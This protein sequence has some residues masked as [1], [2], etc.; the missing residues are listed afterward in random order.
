[1]EE[2]I[3]LLFELAEKKYGANNWKAQEM[4]VDYIYNQTDVVQRVNAKIMAE[5]N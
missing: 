5:I 4:F 3:A 1:M 2:D